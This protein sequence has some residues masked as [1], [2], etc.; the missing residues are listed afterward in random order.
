MNDPHVW[1]LAALVLAAIILMVVSG[2]A[3]R[4]EE[5]WNYY[6]YEVQHVPQVGK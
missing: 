4:D 6:A 5:P 3:Q 2:C 1:K